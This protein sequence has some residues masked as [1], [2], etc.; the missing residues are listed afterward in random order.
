MK[1]FVKASD[2]RVPVSNSKTELERIL[3][4]PPPAALEG[5]GR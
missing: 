2:T 5:A 1:R 3:K 4:L